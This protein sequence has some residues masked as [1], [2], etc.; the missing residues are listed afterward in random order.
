MKRA[1]PAL[2]SFRQKTRRLPPNVCRHINS[3]IFLNHPDTISTRRAY[4]ETLRA[5]APPS[6]MH[7]ALHSDDEELYAVSCIGCGD[8]CYVVFLHHRIGTFVKDMAHE[9]HVDSL[10]SDDSCDHYTLPDTVRGWL[11]RF[12]PGDHD[13]CYACSETA[14]WRSYMEQGQCH[15]CY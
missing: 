8:I 12:R 13:L 7:T 14:V 15:A 9:L 2:A 3:F 11:E 4:R 6:T 5:Q 1:G 10:V